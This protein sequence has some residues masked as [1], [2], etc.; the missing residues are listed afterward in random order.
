[1]TLGTLAWLALIGAI[2]V[3]VMVAN[4]ITHLARET[5]DAVESAY[6]RF[7]HWLG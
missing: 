2:A 3:G 6:I 7:T 1:M 5:W 4:F